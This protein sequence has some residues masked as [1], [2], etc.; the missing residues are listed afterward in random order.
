MQADRRDPLQAHA[1]PL[2]QHQPAGLHRGLHAHLRRGLGRE[3][4]ARG[5]RWLVA[6]RLLQRGHR[7]ADRL[8]FL[9]QPHQPVLQRGHLR[10]AGAE[11]LG[12]QPG[13]SG[14]GVRTGGDD[15]RRRRRVAPGVAQRLGGGH[16]L[17]QDAE[18]P[19]R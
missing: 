13:E 9:P 6:H 7:L 15:G 2:R 19:G 12:Q 4:E 17:G 3:R 1:Q 18:Q 8:C 11:G 16:I 5:L 14:Q 10:E